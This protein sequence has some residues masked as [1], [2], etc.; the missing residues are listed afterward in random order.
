VELVM[1]SSSTYSNN[2]GVLVTKNSFEDIVEAATTILNVEVLVGVPSDT[3]DRPEHL[4]AQDEDAIT[5]AALAYIHDQGVPEARIPQREF[6]RPGIAD[7][8]PEIQRRLESAM[9]AAMRGNA[10][11]AEQAMHQAGIIAQSGIRNRIDA[12]VPPPLSEY[13]LRRRAEKGRKGAQQE[14][15]LRAAGHAPGMEHAKPLVDTGEMRKS[16]TYV[17]RSRR[18]RR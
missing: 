12:G 3:S 1:A 5:N 9:R 7:V 10:L 2:T 6:M 15:D 17:L 4:A 16:I 13:T 8:L 11:V 18:R 14:L